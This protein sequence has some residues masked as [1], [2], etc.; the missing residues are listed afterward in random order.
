M[1]HFQNFKKF[2]AICLLLIT[3]ISCSPT[4]R[5]VF[6]RHKG[7]NYAVMTDV[8]DEHL[9]YFYSILNFRKEMRKATTRRTSYMTYVAGSL[10]A[11]A[12][13]NGA[14]Q[15][16]RSQISR[17]NDTAKIAFMAGL[18]SLWAPIFGEDTTRTSENIGRFETLLTFSVR[19]KNDADVEYQLCSSNVGGQAEEIC[20]TQRQ[21]KI[22]VL[23]L[24]IKDQCSSLFGD[25]PD[26]QC[27]PE[28]G[29]HSPPS[30][31][32]N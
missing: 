26:I 17:T 16:R 15:D 7:M 30:E 2:I 25:I 21:D 18:A 6:N 9:Q 31:Q 14:I 22:K 28:K 5:F 20:H 3:L 32:K 1:N 27:F 4:P 12:S 10:A 19:R 24:E 11:M 29:L 8:F 23:I 13:L